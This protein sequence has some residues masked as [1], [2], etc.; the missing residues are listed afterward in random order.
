MVKNQNERKR[1]ET[2]EEE[3]DTWDE[4]GIQ[5]SK[6]KMMERDTELLNVIRNAGFVLVN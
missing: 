4:S 5:E 6:R 1:M 3:D 2:I